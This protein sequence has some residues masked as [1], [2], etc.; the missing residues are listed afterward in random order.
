MDEPGGKKVGDPTRTSDGSKL[1]FWAGDA[2]RSRVRAGAPLIGDQRIQQRR[3]AAAAAVDHRA[4]S[5]SGAE[6]RGLDPPLRAQAQ[7]AAISW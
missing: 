7:A 1:A 6:Q 4:D 5:A 2:S 3:F